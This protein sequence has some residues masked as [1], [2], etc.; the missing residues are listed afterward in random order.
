MAWAKIDNDRRSARSTRTCSL[1]L[2]RCAPDCP[3]RATLGVPSNMVSE[4]GAWGTRLS[5]FVGT[6]EHAGKLR[7][8]IDEA[9]NIFTAKESAKNKRGIRLSLGRLSPLPDVHMEKAEPCAARVVEGGIEVELPDAL[10]T[11]PAAAP[12]RGAEKPGPRQPDVRRAEPPPAPPPSKPPAKAN[13]TPALHVRGVSLFDDAGQERI[14]FKGREAQLTAR[15]AQLARLLMP[16]AP[17]PIDRKHLINKLGIGGEFAD[18]QL[19]GKVGELRRVLLT[20]G[21]DVKAIK[22]IGVALAIPE[23]GE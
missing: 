15:M 14:S 5:V 9:G 11:K 16:G 8:E 13:G 3:A 2:R 12:E 23:A 19:N 21:L 10:K 18:V 7:I 22:G 4:I 1:R 17:Q 20:V 6:G